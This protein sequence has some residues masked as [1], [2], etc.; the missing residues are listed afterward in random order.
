M[1]DVV[2]TVAE[3][4]LSD[5]LL[6]VAE[7]CLNKGVFH[8]FKKDKNVQPSH[9]PRGIMRYLM[10]VIHGLD[11]RAT[12]VEK[13]LEQEK[14]KVKFLEELVASIPTANQLQR[15]VTLRTLRGEVVHT[16]DNRILY[17]QNIGQDWRLADTTR[18]AL[19]IIYK[20]IK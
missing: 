16:E 13:E 3:A 7:D 10:H 17:R 4:E 18:E 20:E 2:I 19:D 15:D 9:D 14:A 12:K 11:Y 8:V 5:G 6:A 1:T